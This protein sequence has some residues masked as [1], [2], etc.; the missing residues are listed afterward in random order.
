MLFA[1]LLSSTT[2]RKRRASRRQWA[3]DRDAQNTRRAVLITCSGL[4]LAALAI[5]LGVEG[6]H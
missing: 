5:I 2:R 6:Y 3:A 4:L 1:H